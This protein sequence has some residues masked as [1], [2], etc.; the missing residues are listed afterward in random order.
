LLK[1]RSLLLLTLLAPLAVVL[2]GCGDSHSVP[3]FTQMVFLSDRTAVPATPLFR[4]KLDG[5]GVTPVPLTSGDAYYS[6]VSADATK[7]A[8]YLN[9]DAWVQN[10]DGSES[11]Q[12]TTTGNIDFV[13]ISPDGKKVVFNDGTLHHLSIIN[14]DGTDKVDLTPTL[15]ASMTDCFSAGFSGDGKQIAFVCEGTSVYGIYTVKTDGTGTATVTASRTK[16]TD[17]PSFSPDNKKVFF[18]GEDDTNTYNVESI[19]L[20]GSGD[21]VVVPNTYEAVV[22]NSNIYYASYSSQLEL[23]QV[24]K[25]GMDGSGVISLSDGTHTD[26]LGLAQ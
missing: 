18:I 5:T 7:V 1:T 3:Q 4:Q 23:Y 17:L 25:A 22:L 2:T 16:W 6:S 24:Y 12:L 21:V 20:D 9:G 15:P 26:Y 10:A 14:I 13:R 19:N 8:L 11:L